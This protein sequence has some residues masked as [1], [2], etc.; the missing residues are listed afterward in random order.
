MN[1]KLIFGLAAMLA[2]AACEDDGTGVEGDAMS[3]LEATALASEIAVSSQLA[4][5][6]G[7][8]EATQT[9]GEGA[10]TITLNQTTTHPC[11]AGGQI[12]V[13]LEATVDYDQG[14]QSFN[15]DAG[16][17]LTH[18][19]CGVTRDGVTFTVDGDPALSFQAHAAADGGEAVGAWTSGAA[20]AFLWSASDGRTGRC[21]IDLETITDFTETTRTVQGEVCGHTIDQTIDW[22]TTVALVR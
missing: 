22:T 10:G 18:A 5:T 8:T 7:V 14:A 9:G 15:L 3:E 2:L 6:E 1:R 17:T 20:G 19:D 21:V 11:P 13:A 12:A 16:G 4:T